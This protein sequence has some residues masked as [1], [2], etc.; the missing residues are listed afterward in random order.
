ME[1]IS[2]ESKTPA[3][4]INWIKFPNL[5]RE[6]CFR[7]RPSLEAIVDQGSTS[8]LVL[9]EYF[10]LRSRTAFVK[11][12]ASVTVVQGMGDQCASIDI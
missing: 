4:P 2:S 9:K 5:H 12:F 7:R 3:T 11:L 8:L 1:M 6:P 10:I